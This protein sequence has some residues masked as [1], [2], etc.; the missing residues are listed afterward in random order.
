ALVLFGTFASYV[1][2]EECPWGLPIEFVERQLP[3]LVAETWGTG[4]DIEFVAP[5]RKDDDRL[6]QWLPRGE[7]LGTTAAP[8]SGG[9]R[10]RFLQDVRD[11]LAAVRVPTLVLHRRD[12]AVISVEA[13]RYLAE[14]VH[15][16][17]FVELLGADDW[18]FVGDADAVVDE[19]E[20]FLTGTRSGA[21]GD[22]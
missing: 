11:R 15:G 18:F 2:D 7:R 5:S 8:A 9:G 20:E 16:A 6:R 4:S 13:G 14:H 17:K 10:A 21:E 1:Q 12:D 3:N 22:V 19:I